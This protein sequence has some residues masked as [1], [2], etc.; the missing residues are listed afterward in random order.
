[1]VVDSEDD[2]ASDECA[3]ADPGTRLLGRAGGG[4][5]VGPVSSASCLPGRSLLWVDLPDAGEVVVGQLDPGGRD[6][7]EPD[8]ADLV[9]VFHLGER[10][11]CLLE[12]RVRVRA[13]VLPALTS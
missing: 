1:V 11:D 2:W 8:V 12:R 9:G 10:A 7:R 5:A 13:V 6:V 4:L 3:A